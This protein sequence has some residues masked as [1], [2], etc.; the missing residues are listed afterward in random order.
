MKYVN[1]NGTN[2]PAIGFGTFELEPQDAKA[3]TTHALKTGYRH[4]DT[5]QIYNNEEAVG[6]GIKQSGVAR[7]DIFLT[8]K[9]WIDSYADGDLQQ[10]TQKSLDRLGTDYVDL[11]LLH[12]PNPDV[13][14]SET[15][16]ALNDVRERGL[17]RNIGI[18]NFTST[19]IDEAVDKSRAPLVVNQVE[20]HPYLSQKP[21]KETLG[22]HNMALTAYCPLA[23]GSVFSDAT[24][25]RIGKA[26]GKNAGQVTLRWLIQQG[27]V[28]AIPRS[29]NP[30]HVDSNFDVFDFELTDAQMQDIT[31]LH[32]DEGRIISPSFAPIW[33]NAA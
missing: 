24:L 31:A 23:Q 10:A 8:T 4:I 14:L 17:T 32:R 30:E 33:D 26:H 20:Y 11:L 5:A 19:L 2:I 7:E 25:A 15:M 29:T 28:I 3:M 9:V 12:W 18:S 1:A 6:A 16:D 22:K 13:A 27:D 21:V